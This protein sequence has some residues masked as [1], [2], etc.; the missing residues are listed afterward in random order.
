MDILELIPLLIFALLYLFGSSK[1]RGEEKK[2]QEKVDT[3]GRNV[4]ATEQKR[5]GLQD[6][7]EEAL[8][9]MEQRIETES[10]TKKDDDGV[11][12]V[13][14][15]EEIRVGPSAAERN[16]QVDPD[17]VS[18]E[19]GRMTASTLY[20]TELLENAERDEEFLDGG[21]IKAP[22]HSGF[23][24]R[25]DDERSARERKTADDRAG[26]Q[27]DFHSLFKEIPNETYHGRGFTH[28]NE[29]HGLHFGERP[30]PLDVK[31]SRSEE[32]H[33]AGGIL[34]KRST[35]AEA[36]APTR[37]ILHS[38]VDLRRAIILAEILD[39][40][41]SQRRAHHPGR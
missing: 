24:V 28:F 23:G 39:R 8:Q 40:P 2:R 38:P 26:S 22:G 37:S 10:A 32:F 33:E 27:Y 29:A 7:L 19:I 36:A 15:P 20:A 9:Q 1:K 6:R 17:T 11:E 30:D 31:G 4:P 21:V 3:S 12:E 41:V 16:V 25:L 18:N 34:A 5:R 13:R 35:P 14:M